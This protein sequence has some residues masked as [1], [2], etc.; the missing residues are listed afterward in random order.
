M[1]LE[2]QT[3]QVVLWGVGTAGS[4]S[5]SGY[6]SVLV[7]T[8][9]ANHKFKLSA[10][11][12]SNGMDVTLIA[13]NEMIEADIVFVPDSADADF[14]QPFSTISLSGF[15]AAVLN[16]DWLYVGDGSVDLGHKEGKV[17]LKMRR[18]IN[19]PNIS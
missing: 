19:N 8:G 15:K 4:T 9:K 16:G 13:T 1:S 5:V 7:D 2:I 11:Q 6:G 18:Y 10:I 3:G 12:N 17:S 14:D